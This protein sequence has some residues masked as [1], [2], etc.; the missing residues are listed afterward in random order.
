MKKWIE[1]LSTAW[2]GVRTHKLRSVLTSLG[3]VIGVASV[4]ALMSIGRGLPQISSIALG[5]WG[6]TSLR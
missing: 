6:R 3:I 4:I 5:A 2:E 1:P